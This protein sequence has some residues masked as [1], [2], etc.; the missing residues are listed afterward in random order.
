MTTTAASSSS[1]VRVKID[2]VGELRHQR[3][4]QIASQ[5]LFRL[6]EDLHFL[7]HVTVR[8]SGLDPHP[9]S[10]AEL[11]KQLR[12]IGSPALERVDARGLEEENL[13]VATFLR[14]ADCGDR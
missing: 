2:Y 6:W 13:D 12:E 10:L 8:P 14:G 3:Y 1:G 5:H 11:S 4:P 9:P 7:D